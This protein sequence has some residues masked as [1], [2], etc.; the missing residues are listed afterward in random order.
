[1]YTMR[2]NRSGQIGTGASMAL[3][4]SRQ[5]SARQDEKSDGRRR[6]REEG[7]SKRGKRSADCFTAP[8]DFN[9]RMHLPGALA[10]RRPQITAHRCSQ[11]MPGRRKGCV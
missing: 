5:T 3:Q 8:Q 1:M 6:E 7:K 2:D 10:E 4:S 11:D 9:G